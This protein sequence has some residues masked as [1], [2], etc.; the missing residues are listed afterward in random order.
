MSNRLRLLASSILINFAIVGGASADD[1]SQ[2]MNAFERFA[3]GEQ[4]LSDGIDYFTNQPQSAAT[5]FQLAAVQFLYAVEGLQQDLH[6]LGAG[7]T[8]IG[9]RFT[10]RAIPILRIPVPKNEAPETATYEDTRQ[11]LSTFVARL[12]NVDEAL[13]TIM[14]EEFS[15]D[16]DLFK[17]A[18]DANSDGVVTPDERLLALFPLINPNVRPSEIDGMIEEAGLNAMQISFDV[19]DAKWLQGYANLLAGTGKL[20]LAFDYERTYNI[21]AQHIFGDNANQVGQL[22]SALRGDPA[23]IEALQSEIDA[24]SKQMDDARLTT[25]ERRRFSDYSRLNSEISGNNELTESQKRTRIAE[26]MPELTALSKKQDRYN[27]LRGQVRTKQEELSRLTLG[28]S[29][30][31][32]IASTLFEPVA[33]IHSINWPV[34]NAEMLAEVRGHW[35]KVMKLNHETWSLVA[36]ETDD[37]NEWL[38]NPNQTAPFDGITVSQEQINA[39]LVLAEMGEKVLNGELL[40]PSWRLPA[41]INVKT[42]FETAEKFDLVSFA[43]GHESVLYAEKG[44]MI[45]QRELRDLTRSLGRNIGLFA[46]WFN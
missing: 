39:W 22:F 28:V 43:T 16:I 8:S 41:G 14:P 10:R 33:F 6:R 15:V 11:I 24:L 25:E 18:V 30:L 29:G 26:F 21:S 35:L 31:R 42:F 44:A 45:D 23:E 38:P 1:K 2:N 27:V 40:I 46:V 34:E 13:D 36:G 32:D 3:Y 17:L 20:I 12:E 7:N 19:A 37:N 5:T 9:D 4:P